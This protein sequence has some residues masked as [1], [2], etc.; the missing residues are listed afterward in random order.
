MCPSPL[1]Y[2]RHLLTVLHN[3]KLIFN[4][5]NLSWIAGNQSSISAA[6]A[7]K[8]ILNAT[9]SVGNSAASVATGQATNPAGNGSANVAQN[10]VSGISISLGIGGSANNNAGKNELSL[11]SGNSTSLT[12]KL[13]NINSSHFQN[14]DEAHNTMSTGVGNNTCNGGIDGVDNNN[15]SKDSTSGRGILSPQTLQQITGS[16]G[17]ARD[18]NLFHSP[19]TTSTATPLPLLR[20]AYQPLFFYMLPSITE[21]SP[22]SS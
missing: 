22:L 21:M 8:N 1:L 12:A 5:Y 7:I 11:C 20:G 13:N 18:R 4:I 6:A 16:P 14:G 10:I 19:S 2:H 9:K 17:R 3:S 15:C